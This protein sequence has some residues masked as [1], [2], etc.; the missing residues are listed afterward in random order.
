VTDRRASGERG[1]I[2]VLLNSVCHDMH[3]ELPQRTPVSCEGQSRCPHEVGIAEG[4]QLRI[5]LFLVTVPI[6]GE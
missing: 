5:H 3:Q 4:V 2:G 1:S 6:L